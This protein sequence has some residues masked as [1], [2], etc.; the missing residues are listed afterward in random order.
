MLE[1][2]LIV[3]KIIGFVSGGIAAIMWTQLMWFGG[4]EWSQ[5]FPVFLVAMIM[6]VLSIAVVIAALREHYRALI[7]L[8]VISFFPIG[9]SIFT[10][11]HW[12]RWVS[13]VNIGFLL[14]GILMWRSQGSGQAVH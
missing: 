8:F 7:V 12:I 1:F 14:A 4:F 13:L 2:R 11:D 9:I 3:G 10:A 6:V 5:P